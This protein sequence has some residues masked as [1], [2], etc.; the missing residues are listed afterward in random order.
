M[1]ISVSTDSHELGRLSATFISGKL[2]EVIRDKGEAR[3]VLSTGAS[4]FD[5]FESLIRLDT[6]WTKVEVFH[7]DE[8]IGLPVTHP[9]SFRKYLLERFVNHVPLKKFHGI[10]TD[11]NINEKI[12]E[13]TAEIRKTEVDL[14]VIGIGIN[15][16]IAFND[17]PAD[18]ETLEAF[19]IVTLD[20]VCRMQQVGEG[21]FSEIDEVPERAVSMTIFQIMQCKTI[22]SCVPHEVKADAVFKTFSNRLTNL[23][24]ATM[25]KHHP[26]FHLYLDRNSASRII[27]L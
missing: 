6:D 25:L 24:P 11:G 15:G 16:H 17:P 5:M 3:M 22:V 13:L 18:F 2:N 8:Y 12:S 1:N 23:V 20:K 9:A 19:I 10:D 27:V 26:D 4:Q 14:G 21:W 7:L